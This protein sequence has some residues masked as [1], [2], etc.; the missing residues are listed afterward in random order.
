MSESAGTDLEVR[1]PNVRLRIPREADAQRLFELASDPEVTRFFSWGPY[2]DQGE[3]VAWLQTLPQR[4]ADGIALELA[5]VDP[6]DWVIG[7]IAVLEVSKR[8]RRS[9][10][11]IWLGQAYWGTG[12]SAESEAL[13][14]HLVFGP[15]RMERLGA[16][17][18]VR[19]PRSQRAFER[20][21][22]VREGTLRAF[23][24]HGDERRDLVAY[25]LLRDEWQLSPLAAVKVELRGDVPAA[26]VCAER[27]PS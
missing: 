9:V 20:I 6:D 17:V 2:E 13:L 8:D 18:D 22:Y 14:A 27:P 15:L 5:I 11:G 19:N 12:A 21:G 3:A 26:F 16:W 25:S 10:V 1:G 7:V 24:R 4:R 23:H